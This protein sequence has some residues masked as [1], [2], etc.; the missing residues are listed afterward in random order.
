MRYKVFSVYDSAIQCYKQPF[1]CLSRGEALRS[2]MQAVTDKELPFHQSP[3]DYTLFEIGEYDDHSGA[4]S[5]LEAKVNLG[6]A[7]QA[8]AKTKE[9]LT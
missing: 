6:T 4:Y 7:T 8:M 3:A 5:M 9:E 2:W 1:L